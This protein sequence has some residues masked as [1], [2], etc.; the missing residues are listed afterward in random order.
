MKVNF[1][2]HVFIFILLLS[3]LTI[4]GNF[5]NVFGAPLTPVADLT[6]QWSGFAQFTIPEGYCEYSGK[7]NAYLKQDGNNIVGEF[8]WVATSS[9]SI[10]PEIYQCDYSGFTY[11]DDIQG[12]ISGSQLTLQSSEARFNGWYASSGINLDI[13]FED[14]MI[15]I[16]Q[17]SPTGF[18]PQPVAPKD[19]KEKEPVCK[20]GEVL[21][22]GKCI[23]KEQQEQ[24]EKEKQAAEKAEKERHAALEAEKERHAA[25]EAEK[26]RLA[27]QEADSAEVDTLL[28]KV[29]EIPPKPE[30]WAEGVPIE[31]DTPELLRSQTG[32]TKGTPILQVP[33]PGELKIYKGDA[34]IT[35]ADGK[36]V[37]SNKL[38]IGQTIQTGD[39]AGT[40]VQIGLEGGG[41][42]NLK[43]N[44]KLSTIDLSLNEKSTMDQIKEKL[45]SFTSF[46]GLSQ[47]ESDAVFST[48]FFTG[49]AL[50]TT[51]VVAT[52]GIG[53]GAA[54]VSG[55]LIIT[56]FA[57]LVGGAYFSIHGIDTFTKNQIKES[58]T[59]YALDEKNQRVIFTPHAVL[60]PHGTEFTVT[61]EEGETKLDV[62]DGQVFVVPLDTNQPVTTVTSGNSILISDDK[63][64]ETTLDTASVDKWWEVLAEQESK[65]GGCLIATA[66]FGS[67][68]VPQVQFLRELR[69][70]TVLS[71][72]SGASFMTAFNTFYYLFSPTVADLER[73]NPVFKE[74]VKVAITPLL[75]S[76]S[77][78]QY[79]DIDSEAEMLGYGIG[80]IL[81]NIGMYFVA[82]AL[83]IFK[84]KNKK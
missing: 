78:L 47:K 46:S 7:V 84:L 70:N 82:P 56:G 26:E 35:T 15:G 30:D 23:S 75:S 41:T 45:S 14:S 80:I 60:F 34:K 36:V 79:V 65:S 37:N 13:V 73:Q 49:L 43:E 33:K 57:V 58:F 25:L 2:S 83:I 20:Q 32:D 69:D 39:K 55:G 51:A 71:T 61:V 64:E 6:G 5:Q 18:T 4:T 31:G 63:V 66:T 10:D 72:A 77:L 21:V 40:N 17:L 27:A 44:T 76:L 1:S 48:A 50:G 67:E 12:T 38:E 24:A 62:M 42:I 22:N 68:L 19:E 8:S 54:V 52:A 74:T 29:M 81:L 3:P 28:K 9:K 53:A 59:A 11:A 16:T